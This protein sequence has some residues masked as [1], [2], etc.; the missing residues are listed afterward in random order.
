MAMALP[1]DD[2]ANTSVSPT[3]NEHSTQRQPQATQDQQQPNQ[4]AAPTATNTA[5]QIKRKPSRRANT[6]ERRATHNAVERQRRETLNG[7]FLDLAAL[8]PNL[9]Q[10]RRPSKS[11]I[12]NSSIAHINASRRHRLLAARELR[13]VKLESDALRREL[14]EWRDRAALPRIEEPMRS[15]GFSMILSGELEVIAAVPGD[16]DEEDG[17]DGEGGNDGGYGGAYMDDIEEEGPYSTVPTQHPNA[18]MHLE[19]MDDPRVAAMLKNSN[20]FAHNIPPPSSA[21]GG[22][23]PHILP[24]PSMVASYDNSIAA[25]YEQAQHHAN[26]HPH[27]GHNQHHAYTSQGTFFHDHQEKMHWNN[28]YTSHHQQQMMH[29]QQQQQMIQAQW[30]L[31]TPPA[32][33]HGLPPNSNS[34]PTNGAGSHSNHSSPSPPHS[35]SGSGSPPHHSTSSSSM[36]SSSAAFAPDGGYAFSGTSQPVPMRRRRSASSAASG[37]G[38]VGSPTGYGGSY[39]SPAY[40]ASPS[41]YGGSY[42]GSPPGNGN[43]AG[44]G[45]D[46][47]AYELAIGQGEYGFFGIIPSLISL[48]TPPCLFYYVSLRYSVLWTSLR[49]LVAD[50]Q[51]PLPIPLARRL[52]GFLPTNSLH[53]SATT[54]FLNPAPRLLRNSHRHCSIYTHVASCPLPPRCLLKAAPHFVAKT[55]ASYSF[56]SSSFKA[57]SAENS[58]SPLPSTYS[59]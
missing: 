56:D 48:P 51:I 46:S 28:M 27:Q 45:G 8:L 25:L 39:G 49:F 19:E 17:Y 54:S 23:L 37:S 20:P 13:L 44:N 11:S 35:A 33:S 7:R 55:P 5:Q 47:P 4:P 52:V 3:Q 53:P 42:T 6:A 41:G 24:R 43:N 26:H 38:Y 22:G 57:C 12:V 21:T 58:L 15:D 2:N 31:Y 14:N 32:T 36:V 30:S 29:H 16:G 40:A 50:H 10:I 1:P 18:Q 9:S 34:H 59:M